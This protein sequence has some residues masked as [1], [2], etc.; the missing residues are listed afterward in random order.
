M[1]ANEFGPKCFNKTEFTKN[2]GIGKT[3]KIMY[4]LGVSGNIFP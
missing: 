3:P 2:R 1:V 4:N